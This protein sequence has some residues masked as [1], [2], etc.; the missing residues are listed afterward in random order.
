[1]QLL[2]KL[3]KGSDTQVILT[4]F[5]Y[6]VY[7]LWYSVSQQDFYYQVSKSIDVKSFRK[8][9]VRIKLD[10]IRTAMMFHGINFEIVCIKINHVYAWD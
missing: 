7:V 4:D 5:W 10:F 1:M 8:Y 2:L 9:V 6:L 3:I